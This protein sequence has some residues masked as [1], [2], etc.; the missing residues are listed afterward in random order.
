MLGEARA[1]RSCTPDAHKKTGRQARFVW[2]R[3]DSICRVLVFVLTMFGPYA[4]QAQADHD[5][6]HDQN[7]KENLICLHR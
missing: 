1:S 2:K 6:T 7:L 4:E 5:Q 3:A